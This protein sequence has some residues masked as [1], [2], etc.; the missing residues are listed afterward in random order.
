MSL[1]AG[2]RRGT[3]HNSKSRVAAEAH[4]PRLCRRFGSAALE[5]DWPSYVTTVLFF[6]FFL[7]SLSNPLPH[8]WGGCLLSFS[9]VE[10]PNAQPPMFFFFLF[11]LT[12][13]CFFF[14]RRNGGD[15]TRTSC[16]GI[17]SDKRER[18]RVKNGKIKVNK[19]RVGAW[20]CRIDSARAV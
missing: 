4:C 19:L 17:Q 2:E 14:F 13:P 20:Q 11:W 15:V 18:E 10:F 5:R 16:I 1:P 8:S 9:S 6:F 3:Q 7:H 12:V